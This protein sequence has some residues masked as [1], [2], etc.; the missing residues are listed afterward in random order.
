[1]TTSD[2]ILLYV[3]DEESDRILMRFAFSEE[4]LEGILRMVNHGQEAIDYLSATGIYADREAHPS[5]GLVLLDLNLPEV[6][7]F[8]VLKWIREHALLK[9]LPV[10]IFSSSVREEDR[11]RARSLGADDFVQK[12]H[13]LMAL[14]QVARALHQKWFAGSRN[15]SGSVRHG[16]SQ[17]RLRR[18]RK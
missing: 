10:V 1:M 16:R 13:S 18:V 2:S 12:P 3:E 9:A 11:A 15:D 7:G 4:G 6:H 17:S 5:P 8:D 14:R